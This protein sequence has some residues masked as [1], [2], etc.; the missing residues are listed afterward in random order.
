MADYEEQYACK[1]GKKV[2]IEIDDSTYTASVFDTDRRQIGKLEFDERHGALKLTWAYLD[3]LGSE[4]VH[5]G[6]GRRCVEIVKKRFGFQIIAEDD[7]GIEK[8]DG[9]HLTG[10]APAF[11]TQMREEGRIAHSAQSSPD[12]DEE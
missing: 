12:L 6:I 1:S 9:S 11:V 4:Y 2:L 10:N 5:Q 7:D 3:W 8:D